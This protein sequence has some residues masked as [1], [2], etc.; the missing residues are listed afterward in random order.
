M[1]SQV[2]VC[3]H[4]Y[5]F[6]ARTCYGAVGTHPTGMLSCF[7]VKN[8]NNEKFSFRSVFCES[9]TSLYLQNSTCIRGMAL[10]DLKFSC[11]VASFVVESSVTD[12]EW[13]ENHEPVPTI[14]G[15]EK[16]S[17]IGDRINSRPL[18]PCV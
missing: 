18:A 2:S 15:Q 8:G 14:I 10:H 17:T 6:I 7:L 16:T 3:P 13:Q 5:L 4:G 1:F 9:F 12:R 11:T